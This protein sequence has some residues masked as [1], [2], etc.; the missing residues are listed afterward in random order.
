MKNGTENRRSWLLPGLTT[1]WVVLLKY[2]FVSCAIM[3]PVSTMICPRERVNRAP[4]AVALEQLEPRRG[5]LQEQR[6]QVDVLVRCGPDARGVRVARDRR[7]RK[8]AEHAVAVARHLAEKRAILAEVERTRV[9]A[10]KTATGIRVPARI[11]EGLGTSKKPKVEV[12]IKGFTYRTSIAVMGGKFMLPVSAAS[13]GRHA[14]FVGINAFFAAAF[15][16][17]QRWTILPVSAL[18]AQQ[19]HSHGVDLVRAH[20]E[21]RADAQSLVV[22]LFLPVVLAVAVRLARRPAVKQG[23]S[24]SRGSISGS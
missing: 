10:G 8:D 11:V 15:F 18:V 17:C 24:I 2:P 6:H 20:Q 5:G 19:A 13:S 4:G 1:R 16:R 21:G 14:V 22:L 12:T 7:V 9:T 23:A 3:S